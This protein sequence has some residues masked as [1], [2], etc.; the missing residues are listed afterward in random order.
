[1]ANTY[2]YVPGTLLR[3]YYEKSCNDSTGKAEFLF[4]L[5][6]EKTEEKRGYITFCNKPTH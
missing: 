4:M 1:M 3:A 2:F 5:S 6:D